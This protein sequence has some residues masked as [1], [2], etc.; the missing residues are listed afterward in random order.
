MSRVASMM[1]F[2][3]FCKTSKWDSE[4]NSVHPRAKNWC[5]R[6]QQR[7]TPKK[8]PARFF[9]FKPFPM[10]PVSHIFD[11][12][13]LELSSSILVSRWYFLDARKRCLKHGKSIFAKLRS[14]FEILAHWR[15]WK[16][17]FLGRFHLDCA[18]S[19]PFSRSRS[20]KIST[21]VQKWSF[22]NQKRADVG[23]RKSTCSRVF[24]LRISLE[25][26]ILTQN[27]LR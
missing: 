5:S 19:C 17:C 8:I 18:N 3:D 22:Q 26:S 21:R 12:L 25:W 15:H 11:F 4:P 14:K 2:Q 9:D 13:L 24:G 20:L 7:A 27:E 23:I 16:L 1:E 10:A 6:S